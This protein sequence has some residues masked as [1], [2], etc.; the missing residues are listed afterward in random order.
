LALALQDTNPRRRLMAAWALGVCGP[1]TKRAVSALVPVT[2]DTD[3]KCRLA[4]IAALGVAAKESDE[5]ITALVG[6]LAT[7]KG[8]YEGERIY[9]EDDYTATVYAL[10]DAGPRAVPALMSAMRSKNGRVASGAANALG[11]MSGDALEAL[12]ELERMLRDPD[13]TV[14]ACATRVLQHLT[15]SPG[16][17]IPNDETQ[18]RFRQVGEGAR[19]LLKEAGLDEKPPTEDEAH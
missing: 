4:S 18:R 15:E 14:R 8:K 2:H 17:T 16:H 1:Y 10:R 9:A 13:E 7:A 12:P 6:L 5:A 3:R 19:R 11:Q